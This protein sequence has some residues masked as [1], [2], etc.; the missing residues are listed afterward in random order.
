MFIDAVPNCA[1]YPFLRQLRISNQVNFVY[2]LKGTNLVPC[3]GLPPQAV[4]R[5]SRVV[6][7]PYKSRGTIRS[8]LDDSRLERLDPKGC[9][10]LGCKSHPSINQSKQPE[11]AASLHECTLNMLA[12]QIQLHQRREK[13]VSNILFISSL[14]WTIKQKMAR[15]HSKEGGNHLD[16]ESNRQKTM[17][18]IDGGLHPA[19]DGQKPRRKAKVVF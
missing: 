10:P 5:D 16:R 2:C 14:L 7:V 12:C 1:Q 13:G 9:P 11:R 17:E 6:S 8:N 18:D 19:V 15:R 3:L 4:F